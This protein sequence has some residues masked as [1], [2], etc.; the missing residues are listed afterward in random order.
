MQALPAYA[1]PYT[2]PLLG[3]LTIGVVTLGGWGQHDACARV[4]LRLRVRASACAC[5]R[6][7]ARLYE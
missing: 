2:L 5:V 7:R 3:G 1:A 4:C 6:V